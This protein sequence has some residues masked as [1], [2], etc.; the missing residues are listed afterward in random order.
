MNREYTLDE[1]IEETER[2][3]NEDYH[4]DAC[5]C[6]RCPESCVSNISADNWASCN[7]RAVLEIAF[8]L[9]NGD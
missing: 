5:G 1:I 8:P 6:L 7:V 3:M 2:I 9:L 4:N